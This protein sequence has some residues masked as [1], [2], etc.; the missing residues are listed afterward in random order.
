MAQRGDVYS[1]V[2]PHPSAARFFSASGVTLQASLLAKLLFV[3]PLSMH[4]QVTPPVTDLQSM[5]S[6]PPAHSVYSA[7]HVGPVF[8]VV[9]PQTIS[10]FLEHAVVARVVT[11]IAS[12]TKAKVV[13]CPRL[14]LSHVILASIR[15][16][17]EGYTSR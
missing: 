7:A 16:P 8:S 9:V 12:A 14:R 11:S 3:V 4:A 6:V 5:R 2:Q 1:S 10:S 13:S 17:R 15:G